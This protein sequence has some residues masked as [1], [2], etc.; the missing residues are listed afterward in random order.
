MGFRPAWRWI[1]LSLLM[2][3][4]TKAHL[5]VNIHAFAFVGGM[6]AALLSRQAEFR[7]KAAHPLASLWVVVAVALVITGFDTAY[8]ILPTVLLG[9][10]FCLIANGA[11]VWGLLSASLTRAFGEITYSI[12]LLHGPMLFALFYFIVGYEQAANWSSL[13]HWLAMTFAV[14]VL[15][16]AAV[17]S[18][19][20]IEVTAM[21]WGKGNRYGI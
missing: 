9:T 18:Y 19:R 17:G 5:A 20:W 11:N 10:A 13:Q 15:L 21:D 6:A 14:P 8:A 4:L 12:Y 1:G 2:L 16:A 3:G 7:E